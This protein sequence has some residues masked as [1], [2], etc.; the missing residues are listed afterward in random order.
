MKSKRA[1]DKKGKKRREL[2]PKIHQNGTLNGVLLARVTHQEILHYHNENKNKN[3]K[4]R[5]HFAAILARIVKKKKKVP[6][7][8]ALKKKKKKGYLIS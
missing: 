1:K 8:S 3:F 5:S 4:L 2:I 7:E 6:D